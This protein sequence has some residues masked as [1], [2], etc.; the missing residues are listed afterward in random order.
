MNTTLT[1]AIIDGDSLIFAMFHANKVFDS[2][3]IPTRTEDNKRFVYKEKTC[4]EIIESCDFLMNRTLTDC[5]VE[6]YILFVKGKNTTKSKEAIN[7]EYKA[8]REKSISPK[9]WTFTKEYLKLTWGAIEVD[10]IETDDAV[11]IT[12]LKIKDSFIVAIDSDVLSLSG[13]HFNWNKREW[14]TNTKDYE[15][16]KFWCDM[17]CG[18]HNNC[19][20]IPGKGPKYVEKVFDN[21]LSIDEI[22]A[23]YTYN[24]LVLNE[25]MHYFGEKVG[26]DE[27][28][29]NYKCNKILENYEQ[30]VVPDLIKFSN[31][32]EVDSRKSEEW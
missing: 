5:K 17:I 14:I 19:K 29:K 23:M 32:S 6:S 31:N 3:G 18:T 20:G 9:F 27:F 16:Y 12:N 13:T 1:N 26:I 25:Y 28:Y 7:P 11:R 21:E 8:D 15:E 30:F 4:K 2:N 24:I 10:N 22:G